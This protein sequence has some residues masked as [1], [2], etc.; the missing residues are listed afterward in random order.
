VLSFDDHHAVHP[1]LVVTGDET[2]ELELA[3]YHAS[4]GRVSNAVEFYSL[5]AGNADARYAQERANANFEVAQLH[6]GVDQLAEAHEALREA[7]RFRAKNA[8]IAWL[9]AQLSLDLNDDDGAKRALRVLVS[10][11]SGPE[12]GDDCVTTQTKSKAYYYLGRMLNSQ[13]DASG[14]RRMIGRSLE[15][16]PTNDFAQRLHDRLA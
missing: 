9:F 12:D 15:E 8:G 14:A 2:G 1:R 3:R 10:L 16:D 4:H 11:K 13:G 6:L 5:V 7:F